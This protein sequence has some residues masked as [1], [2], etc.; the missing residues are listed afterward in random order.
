MSEPITLET[1][2]QSPA[3]SATDSNGVIH[4]SAEYIDNGK[5]MILYFYPKDSTP[6]CTKQACDFRD[7]MARLRS[8]GYEVLGVSKD[9]EKSHQKFVTKQEL[10]FPLLLDT[11]GA[12][13]ELFGTW[14]MKKNYGREY[15]G[16]VRSTFVIDSEGNIKW[17]RY[18]V[19]AKGHVEMLLRELSLNE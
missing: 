3:F 8:E 5:S 12:L 7:N 1:G 16:C 15:M 18:N 14:R 11:E 6:G 17:C 2:M 9:S 4:S 10:N 19:R 13:H